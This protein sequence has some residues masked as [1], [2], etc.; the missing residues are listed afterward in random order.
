MIIKMAKRPLSAEENKEIITNVES[1]FWR[2]INK[3]AEGIRSTDAFVQ[4]I[5]L[6]DD[7]NFGYAIINHDQ[8][9]RL[10]NTTP[11]INHI[12]KR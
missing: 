12:L 8:R 9:N 4:L 5:N 1:Y 6:V 11:G 3:I 10:H 7:K 2:S